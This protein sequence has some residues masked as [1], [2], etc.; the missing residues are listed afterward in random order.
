MHSTPK[1]YFKIY[2]IISTIYETTESVQLKLTFYHS[3]LVKSYALYMQ[4]IKDWGK[5]HPATH[6]KS[7]GREEIRYYIISYN[8]ASD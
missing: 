8:Q 7:K 6:Q 5:P 1:I 2:F 4:E 3:L